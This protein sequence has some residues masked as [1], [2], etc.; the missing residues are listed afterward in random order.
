MG[1][2]EETTGPQGGIAGSID[3]LRAAIPP[4]D[5]A[6]QAAGERRAAPGGVPA[7]RTR[8]GPRKPCTRRSCGGAPGER[9]VEFP[10]VF[11]YLGDRTA[12]P[13]PARVR[14]VGLLRRPS[15]RAAPASPTGTRP[16]CARGGDRGGRGATQGEQT[17]FAHAQRRRRRGSRLLLFGPGR[18]A[19]R[20]G[21]RRRTGRWTA[22]RGSSR[23]GSWARGLGPVAAHVARPHARG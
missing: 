4:N 9:R 6:N 8:P 20:R 19:G 1:S 14:A 5:Q 15:G 21:S 16:G 2:R 10:A 11:T 13:I 23:R 22:Q 7:T 3:R 17:Q 12:H 18:H